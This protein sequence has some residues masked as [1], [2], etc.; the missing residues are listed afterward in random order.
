MMKQLMMEG[1]LVMENETTMI[2]PKNRFKKSKVTVEESNQK[3]HK[4]QQQRKN[5]LNAQQSMSELTIY[6]R[7]VRDQTQNQFDN[8]VI[9]DSQE[10]SKRGSSSSADFNTDADTSDET[11]ILKPTED[12]GVIQ[13]K[14]PVFKTV[15][16]IG[17]FVNAST[18]PIFPFA[19]D[20]QETAN[21]RD[22]I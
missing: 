15:P 6:D 12:V 22:F 11:N 4:R 14:T 5:L 10:K 17:N 9:T 1:H 18:S 2:T 16:L 7:A 13:T 20:K 21:A 19:D 8:P 3:D